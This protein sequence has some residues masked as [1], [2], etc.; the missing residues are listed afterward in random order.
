MKDEYKRQNFH[1]KKRRANWLI[2]QKRKAIL[3]SLKKLLETNQP[4]ESY[5]IFVRDE[6]KRLKRS[7]YKGLTEDALVHGAEEGRDKLR[8]ATGRS[9]YPE[10][11]RYPNEGTQ[12]K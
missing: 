12:R 2:A 8:K 11:R 4:S 3:K 9:K 10:S 1:I 7:S 6:Q 5:R